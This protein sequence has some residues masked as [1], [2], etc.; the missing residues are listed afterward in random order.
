MVENEEEK[1]E[2]PR[3]ESD[4]KKDEKE[5]KEKKADE[6]CLEE[7]EQS[8]HFDLERILFPPSFSAGDDLLV[9][10]TFL[11]EEKGEEGLTQEGIDRE[12]K[13][14]EGSVSQQQQGS[15]GEEKR[16]EGGEG[17]KNNDDSCYLSEGFDY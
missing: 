12:E 14:E 13:G 5:E 4:G 8:F 2:F 1:D 7:E 6:S 15:V 9:I 16:R 10:P 3:S 11:G 17:S